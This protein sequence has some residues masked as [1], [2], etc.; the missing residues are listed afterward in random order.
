MDKHF[1]TTDA[2]QCG[3]HRLPDLK[4]Q[5]ELLAKRFCEEHDRANTNEHVARH[6]LGIL[7]RF[8][9]NNEYVPL[10]LQ[11]EVEKYIQA[12]EPQIKGEIYQ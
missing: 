7:R 2:P 8:T 11:E 10:V 12:L 5:N 6:L 1:K 4:T 3:N 9:L